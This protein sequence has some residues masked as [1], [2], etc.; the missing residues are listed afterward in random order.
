V[1]DIL[2]VIDVLLRNVALILL[3]TDVHIHAKHIPLKPIELLVFLSKLIVGARAGIA[4]MLH[5]WAPSSGHSLGKGIIIFTSHRSKWFFGVTGGFFALKLHNLVIHKVC[6][7]ERKVELLSKDE[8]HDKRSIKGSLLVENAIIDLLVNEIHHIKW[9]NMCGL[10]FA[11]YFMRVGQEIHQGP[12]NSI[13][14]TGLRGNGG[15][16]YAEQ[17]V[18]PFGQPKSAP[19]DNL[20]VIP[21]VERSKLLLLIVLPIHMHPHATRSSST[22]KLIPKESSKVHE[23]G[24]TNLF[25]GHPSHGDLLTISKHQG[26]KELLDQCDVVGLLNL[27]EWMEPKLASDPHSLSEVCTVLGKMR[28]IHDRLRANRILLERSIEFLHDQ[29]L[30]S[31][32]KATVTRVARESVH[33]PLPH[34]HKFR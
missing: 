1:K 3:V 10:P 23:V 5:P 15:P 25:S 28:E 26:S 32:D 21:G 6:R 33:V 13:K 4:S 18:G 22:T 8:L 29:L 9:L 27:H 31:A 12:T 14:V 19:N 16:E 34:L 30:L 2:I 17:D 7:E 24:V 11:I 20:L